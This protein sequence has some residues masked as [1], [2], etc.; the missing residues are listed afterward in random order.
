MRRFELIS[1]IGRINLPAFLIGQ[2]IKSPIERSDVPNCS[3]VNAFGLWHAVVYYHHVKK[4]RR[5]ANVGGCHRACQPAR[6]QIWRQC[7][8]PCFRLYDGTHGDFRR[9]SI[10][11]K[12]VLNPFVGV[13]WGGL[14]LK[15]STVSWAFAPALA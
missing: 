1:G 9:H 15:G 12:S 4:G 13:P 7:L 8:V 11:T 2:R 10:W 5:D 6:G 3:T 14:V